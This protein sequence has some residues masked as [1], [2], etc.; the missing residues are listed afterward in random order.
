MEC[1]F[2]QKV[3]TRDSNSFLRDKQTYPE[4]KTKLKQEEGKTI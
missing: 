3:A 1:D 4:Y 2:L